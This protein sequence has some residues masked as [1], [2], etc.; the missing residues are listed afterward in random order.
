MD[1]TELATKMIEWERLTR[2]ADLLAKEIEGAVL[3]LGKTQVVGN[4]RVTYSK[5]RGSYDY[6]PVV[7]VA[8]DELIEKFSEVEVVTNWKAISE[9]MGIPPCYI[10]GTPSATIKLR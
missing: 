3:V 1:P 8:T 5:G 6:A 2:Q 10:P 7:E 4:V 9:E